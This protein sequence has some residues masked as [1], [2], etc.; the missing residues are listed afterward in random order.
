MLELF[1]NRGRKDN[2]LCQ[3]WLKFGSVRKGP[4]LFLSLLSCQVLRK[5]C[6]YIPSIFLCVVVGVL[7][8][9]WLVF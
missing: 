8:A 6:S 3:L 2:S 7:V 9:G 1:I 4:S 5:T